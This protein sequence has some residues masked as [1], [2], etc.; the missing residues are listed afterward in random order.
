[1]ARGHNNGITILLGV[2]DLRFFSNLVAHNGNGDGV[3]IRL[4]LKLMLAFSHL[5]GKILRAKSVAR[6]LLSDTFTNLSVFLP[7]LNKFNS[8]FF[9]FK[10]IVGRFIPCRIKG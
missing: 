5:V 4:Y 10:K 7:G 8:I 2:K 9:L 6:V 1:M 3:D